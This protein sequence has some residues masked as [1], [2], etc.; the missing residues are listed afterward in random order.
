MSPRTR[1][2]LG[3]DHAIVL[4]GLRRLLASDDGFEVI[5]EAT[6]GAQVLNA[7]L[8]E[9]DIL[10]LDLSLP[11]FGGME[12]LRRLRPK[13]P[14]LKFVILSMYPADQYAARLLA[15]GASAYVSKNTRSEELLAT[16]RR[17]ASGRLASAPEGEPRP[18]GSLPHA[19]LT[20]R[21]YQVFTLVCEGLKPTDIAA[22]LDLSIST[23]SNHMAAIKTKLSVDSVAG[24]ITY[25]HRAGIID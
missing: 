15:E 2:Y 24:I 11:R 17:V 4:D 20:A 16:L 13:Y 6:D 18:Q 7:P 9:C 25:A 19:S 22:Q 12:V 14:N 10:L 1:V 23:V 8:D 5:G 21:E 3:D